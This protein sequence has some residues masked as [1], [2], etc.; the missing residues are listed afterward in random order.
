M[1]MLFDLVMAVFVLTGAYLL[2]TYGRKLNKEMDE[3]EKTEVK[4]E[5][6]KSS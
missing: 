6:K 2:V 1:V 3:Q 5:D 4:S